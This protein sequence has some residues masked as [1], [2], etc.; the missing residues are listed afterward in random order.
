MPKHV[1]MKCRTA[2]TGRKVTKVTTAIWWTRRDLRLADNQALNLA[3]NRADTVIPVFIVDPQ[4]MDGSAP[5]R[6]AFLKNAIASLGDEM[7]TRGSQLILRQGEPIQELR[8]LKE[9]TGAQIIIAESDHSPFAK[10]RD[11][12]AAAALP[13]EFTGGVT[14]HP[15]ESVRKPDGSPYTI[16]TPFMKFWKALPMA[17]DPIPAPKSLPAIPELT[18]IELPAAPPI[19]DFPAVENFAYERLREFFHSSIFDYGEARNRM[20]IEGTS[21]LSPYLRFGLISPRGLISAIFRV[22]EETDNKINKQSCITW[23]NE[24]IWREFYFNILDHFPFVLKMSFRENLRSIPWRDMP[25]DLAAWQNG[26]TGYPMVD[27]AMRQLNETGWMHNRARMITASFLTKD[28]LINWQAGESWFLRQLLDGDPASNNGG[29]QWAAGTGTD[30]APYF[31]IFN[32]VL[33]SQKFDPNGDY[34]RRWVPE[35]AKLPKNYIHSPWQTPMDVQS[36][37]GIRMGKDYPLPIVDH[38]FARQRT[39]QAYKSA[40]SD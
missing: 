19:S 9:E 27:A 20:D 29:W 28:L 31:R 30:A 17:G 22:I 7:R 32:P 11:N 1:V 15:P 21:R 23:L 25:S 24:I 26:V 8:R 14:V 39:L 5:K 3:L 6:E 36:Q 13:I 10:A 16:F 12:R 35:L 38:Q 18:S 4:L 33:Q 37:F 40:K 2:S 34:I